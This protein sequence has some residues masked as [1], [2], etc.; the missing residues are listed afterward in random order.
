MFLAGDSG[1]RTFHRPGSVH[2]PPVSAPALFCFPLLIDQLLHKENGLRF[3]V[4]RQFMLILCLGV[5]SM[6]ML[7]L[8]TVAF[9]ADWKGSKAPHWF[10]YTLDAWAGVTLWPIYGLGVGLFI[11]SVINP[12]RAA[13]NPIFLIGVGTCAAISIWYTFATLVL[14]FSGNDPRLLAIVPGSTGVAYSLYCVIIWRNREFTWEDI[15]SKWL[16]MGVWLGGLFAMLAAKI[17]LAMHYYEQL[18]DEQ[19][20]GCFIVTAATR[21][22]RNWVGTWF[23]EE[24]NRLLNQQL[25]TFWKFEAWLKA[26]V[27]RTHRL[28]RRI[29][30]RLGPV[31][32][33]TIVFRWQADLVYLLLKPLEILS[34]CI[35]R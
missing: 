16:A 33:R 26:R 9:E 24:Q 34:R 14:N 17:P 35:V 28:I 3:N 31:I 8:A 30:N 13:R 25:L 1:S 7:M 18:P 6:L 29:Y 22:H 11:H 23:D 2:A 12:F 32:A 15:K 20:E 10:Y 21:G 19:P 4:F 5:Y 27:P